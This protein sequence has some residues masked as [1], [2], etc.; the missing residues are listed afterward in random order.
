M[1]PMNIRED[2]MNM[3]TPNKTKDY[4]SLLLE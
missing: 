2:Y 4:G 1:L 3:C